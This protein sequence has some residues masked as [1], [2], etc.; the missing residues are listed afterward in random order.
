ME[1]FM[2][3]QAKYCK[4]PLNAGVTGTVV[5]T[6]S[7]SSVHVWDSGLVQ[8]DLYSCKDFNEADIVDFMVGMFNLRDYNYQVINRTPEFSA[9]W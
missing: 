8:A 6:T 1:I 7:H 4:D 9:A 3:P 2:P 5:I